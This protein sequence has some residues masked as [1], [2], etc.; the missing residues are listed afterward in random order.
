ML[1]SDAPPEA[2]AEQAQSVATSPAL[3]ADARRAV[4]G[5]NALRLVPRLAR[6]RA[7]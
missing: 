4:E 2:V 7:R 3:D 6:A 5:G 1:G